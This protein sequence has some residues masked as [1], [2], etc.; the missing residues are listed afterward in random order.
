MTFERRHNTIPPFLWFVLCILNLDVLFVVIMWGLSVLLELIKHGCI[1]YPLDSICS[2]LGDGNY[3]VLWIAL[4][5]SIGFAINQ[6]RSAVTKVSINQDAR[7][8]TFV[9]YS[10][11]YLFFK[12]KELTIPFN[13]L[14]YYVARGKS[15]KFNRI[16]S[17]LLPPEMFIFYQDGHFLLQFG[18]TLGWTSIQFKEI[19]CELRKIGPPGSVSKGF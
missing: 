9:Y 3:I 7:E 2:F 12:K 18:R 6:L 11:V 10:A 14:D 4:P 1:R 5:I 15:I 16:M 17:P 19:E 13:R 8:L